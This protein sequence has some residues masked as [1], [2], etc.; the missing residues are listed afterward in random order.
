LVLHVQCYRGC[1]N[2][3]PIHLSCVKGFKECG[4]IDSIDEIA[5]VDEILDEKMKVKLEID[6]KNSKL[7]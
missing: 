5:N 3:W 2:R 4:K 7:F 6:L 1:K